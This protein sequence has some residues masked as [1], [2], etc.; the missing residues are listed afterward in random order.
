VYKPTSPGQRGRIT[1][2]RDGLWKGKPFKALTKGLTKSGGRNNRGR[3]TV[4]H[5]GGGHKRKYRM[6][7]FQRLVRGVTGT[8]R[9]SS[10]TRTGLRE[11]RWWISKTHPKTSPRT[12]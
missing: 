10:T 4:F 12:F 7:D 2:A 8:V 1:T 9:G 3:I 11:S 6:V 5:R